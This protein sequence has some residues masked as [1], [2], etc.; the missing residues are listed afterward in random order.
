MCSLASAAMAVES[1]PP[2]RNAPTVTSARMC[3]AT[4]SRSTASIRRGASWPPPACSTG[5]K[6][7]SASGSP[8]GRTVTWVPDSTRRIARCSVAGSG[9]YCSSR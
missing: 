4:E 2:E 7:R 1:M 5:V 9:T 3:L 8:P 6:Y